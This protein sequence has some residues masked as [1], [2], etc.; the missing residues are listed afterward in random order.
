[1]D[2][3]VSNVRA[4]RFS[5]SSAYDVDPLVAS[6]AMSGF[7]ELA[8]LYNSYRVLGSQCKVTFLTTSAA[9]PVNVSLTPTNLDPGASPS[10]AYVFAAKEQP[11]AK[12]GTTGLTGSPPLKLNSSLTT[13]RMYGSRAV[14]FD[15]S[16]AALVTTV[17]TNNWWW[18][19]SAYSYVLDPS[20]SWVTIIIETDVEFYDRTFLLV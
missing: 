1:M 4:I 8:T 14:L 16:F 12:F 10:S 2:F 11:Y 18:V 7:A 20:L 5:P 6:T 15:D 3:T 9:N 13:E 17:P 19:I